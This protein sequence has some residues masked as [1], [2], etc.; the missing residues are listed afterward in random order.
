MEDFY[1]GIS[2]GKAKASRVRN[3]DASGAAAGRAAAD[4]AD[5]GATR[6]QGSRGALNR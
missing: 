6:I 3:W 2:K 1:N 5:V 4:R